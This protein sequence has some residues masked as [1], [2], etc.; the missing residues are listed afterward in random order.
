MDKPVIYV[1]GNSP[2]IA[3]FILPEPIQTKKEEEV[4]PDAR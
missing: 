2:G 3:D 1:K 4:T